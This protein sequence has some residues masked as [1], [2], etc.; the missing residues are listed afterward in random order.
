[1][2]MNALE[3]TNLGKPKVDTPDSERR[4]PNFEHRT[5]NA[6][7]PQARA[8]RTNLAALRATRVDPVVALR[9]E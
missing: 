8:R 9:H 3:K 4:T 1:M 5:P 2:A 7:E 6:A